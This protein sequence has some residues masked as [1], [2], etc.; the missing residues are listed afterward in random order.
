M[1]GIVSGELVVPTLTCIP[2]VSLT[3]SHGAPG[4][5]ASGPVTVVLTVGV[6]PVV[7]P[8]PVLPVGPLLPGLPDLPVVPVL[9]LLPLLPVGPVGPVAVFRPTPKPTEPSSVSV[10]VASAGISSITDIV[11]S[12]TRNL[13]ISLFNTKKPR[14]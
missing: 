11:T 3:T 5:L 4:Q 13:F 12:A 10:P 1:R 9:P 8:V 2:V 14:S 7:P 6:V